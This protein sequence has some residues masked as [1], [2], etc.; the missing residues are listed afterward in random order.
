MTRAAFRGPTHLGYVPRS[1]LVGGGRVG[2][3]NEHSTARPLISALGLN[4]P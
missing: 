1:P 3:R 4:P 2:H